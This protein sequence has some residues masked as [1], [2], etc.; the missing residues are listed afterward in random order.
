VGGEGE[1]ERGLGGGL[2]YSS[3]P[4][5]SMYGCIVFPPV[6]KPYFPYFKIPLTHPRVVFI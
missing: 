3:T 1:G 5:H 4:G 6:V 2:L